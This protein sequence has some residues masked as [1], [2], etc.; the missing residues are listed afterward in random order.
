MKQQS[1]DSTGWLL[2]AGFVLI[3]YKLGGLD[4][5]IAVVAFLEIMRAMLWLSL[6]ISN[7]S[8]PTTEDNALRIL[9]CMLV[10]GLVVYFLYPLFP[11]HW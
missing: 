4:V 10:A 9:A 5:G 8:Y 6:K 3:G 1:T 11:T 2:Y 7:P